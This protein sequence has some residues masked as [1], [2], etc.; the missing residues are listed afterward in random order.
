MFLVAVKFFLL[1][2]GYKWD[3]WLKENFLA[4][5]EIYD[6]TSSYF[7]GFSA[8]WLDQKRKIFWCWKNPVT[9]W[10]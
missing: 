5:E 1:E 3:L 8:A 7:E 9:M 6:L 10:L 4:K 2:Y